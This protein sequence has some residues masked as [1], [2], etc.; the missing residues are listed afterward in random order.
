MFPGVIQDRRVSWI[1]V[2]LLIFHYKPPDQHGLHFLSNQE[3]TLCGY[4]IQIN[5]V[6]DLVFRS[7]FLA[8]HVHIKVDSAEILSF[9]MSRD[10]HGITHH[11]SISTLQTGTDYHLSLWFVNLQTEEK[12]AVY[13]LRL[14]CSIPGSSWSSREIVCEEKYM[15][16]NCSF[17]NLYHHIHRFRGIKVQQH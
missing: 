12:G 9:D 2:G 14:H 4:T 5:D 7:S 6:G 15:E 16:V 13:P 1:L 8:C 3:A 11:F 17:A 10:F